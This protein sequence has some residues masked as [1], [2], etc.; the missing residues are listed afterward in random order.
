MRK[1]LSFLLCAM[2]LVAATSASA[3]R[4]LSMATL[5]PAGSTWMRVFDAANRDLRRRTGGQLSL[6]WYPGGVQG[7]EGEV[8]RKIRN[9]RLDGAAITA[10]G[11]GLIHRPILAFQLPGMFET[12]EQLVRAR[13]TLRPEIDRSF[14]AQG[15]MLLGFGST[16]SPRMF[17]RRLIRTPADLRQAHP[18]QWR[19][20][21]ILPALYQETGA[22]GVVLQVPEVLSA[23]QT[24][25]VDTV[26]ASPLVAVS[27]QW[28]AN[29]THMSERSDTASLGAII[30]SKQQFQSLPP[31]HQQALREVLHQ[32]DTLLARNVRRDDDQA[33]QLLQQ[34]GVQVVRLNDAERAQWSAVFARVRTRLVGTISDAAWIERVQAAGRG[35]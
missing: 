23:I 13:D 20:D 8:V 31:A 25:R 33:A 15:F 6:R 11:L 19:D 21:L 14:E 24:N 17:S 29:M 12:P 32:Y 26:I 2:L 35:R 7:D 10:V 3:Q 22:T 18:W 9:G 4:V 28:A 27:L 5:A 30:V 16:G 1:V 34:R